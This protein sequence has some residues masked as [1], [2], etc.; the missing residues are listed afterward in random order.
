MCVAT[1][2]VFCKG[3]EA[4]RP[5]ISSTESDESADRSNAE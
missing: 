2:S 1:L 4:G 5:P 3:A